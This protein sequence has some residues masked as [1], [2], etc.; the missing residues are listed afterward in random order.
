MSGLKHFLDINHHDLSVLSDIMDRSTSMK[1]ALIAGKLDHPMAGRT[2][3]MIFEKPSTRTRVSFQVGFQQMGGMT[4]VMGDQE[5]QLGRGETLADT[6]RVLSRYAD[7]IMIRTDDPQKL[8]DLADY[9]SIPV[10]NGLTDD[11]HPC[12]IMADIM[13]FQ[14]HRGSIAGR[15][16]AW[17]GDGNNVTTSWIHAAVQFGFT[18]KLGCPDSLQPDAGVVAWAKEK[19]GDIVL[20]DTAQEAV[21]GVD[22]VTTDTWVSM[23]DK[24]AG[25]RMQVLLPFRVD[26]ALMAHAASDAL[27]MH[28]LPAHRGEE[29]TEE[30]IDGDQSVIWDEAENRL[31]AQKGILSWCLQ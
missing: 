5:S 29:V 15:T 22:L 26:A 25:R 13:T 7:A 18:L 6:A 14:E 10:I 8:Q 19:G 27:F 21:A 9:A 20:A 2:L 4:V 17:V 23:G 16:V 28:C 1:T 11:S 3:V 24:D 31:H 30:V 12:Q